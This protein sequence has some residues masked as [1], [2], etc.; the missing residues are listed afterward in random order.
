MA[1]SDDKAKEAAS[2]TGGTA[3]TESPPA[4]GG[5]AAKAA[6]AA[7]SKGKDKGEAMVEAVFLKRH[8]LAGP[9][10]PG[11]CKTFYPAREAKYRRHRG[12]PKLTR[13]IPAD[14]WRF[15]KKDFEHL[16]KQGIV[17][18]FGGDA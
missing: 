7:K 14:R 1:K 5:N 17:A 2:S 9:D 8:T 6:P 10:Y 16:A 3:P 18:R 12:G 15:S 4:E 11:G 13:T